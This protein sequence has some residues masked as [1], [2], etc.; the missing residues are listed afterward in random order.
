M[1]KILT[2]LLVIITLFSAFIFASCEDDSTSSLPLPS[3]TTVEELFKNVNMKEVYSIYVDYAEEMDEEVLSFEEWFTL[4]KGEEFEKGIIP[5]IQKN[6]SSDF[7]E[8]SYNNGKGWNSL[9][10]KTETE[11]QKNCK[12]AFK[13][14]ITLLDHNEF[15]NGIRYRECKHCNYKEY[16]FKLKHKFEI[17]EIP[18]TCIE[19]GYIKYTCNEKGCDYSYTEDLP[20]AEHTFEGGV[21]TVCG[22][23]S[24]EGSGEELGHTPYEYFTFINNEDG[25]YSIKAKDVNNMPLEVIL[26]STYNGIAVTRIAK[27]GFANCESLIK[28]EIPESYFVI[29]ESAFYCCSNLEEVIFNE[30]SIYSLIG[31]FAFEY[32]TSLTSIDIPEGITYICQETFYGCTALTTVKFP[33]TLEHID[34]LAFGNCYLLNSLEFPKALGSIGANAF[35]NCNSITSVRFPSSIYGIDEYAFSECE[36]LEEVIFEENASIMVLANSLFYNCV[37]L[38]TVKLPNSITHIQPGVFAGCAELTS[39]N[40]LNGLESIARGVFTGCETLEK[41]IIPKS[42]QTM[43]ECVFTNCPLLTI[44]CEAKSQPEGWHVDWNSDK[45]PVV[46]GFNQSASEDPYYYFNFTLLEDDTYAISA[47]YP[48]DM[49]EEIIIPS[50]YQEKAVTVIAEGGFYECRTVISVEIP[51]SIKEIGSMAFSKCTHLTT[52]SFDEESALTTIG[53]GAFSEC[54]KLTTI[55]IPQGVTVIADD[56][57]FNCNS[58]TV[59]EIQGELTAIGARAFK[60]CYQLSSMHIP[61]TVISIEDEAFVNC[62]SLEQFTFDENINLTTIEENVL[63]GCAKLT[64]LSIPQSVTQIKYGAF[65]SCTGLEKVE[66]SK[67]NQ[68]RVIGSGAF[69]ETGIKNINSEDLTQL[70]TIESHAFYGCSNLTSFTFSESVKYLGESAFSSCGSL[71]SVY[72]PQTL[73]TVESGAFSNCDALTAIEVD[74]NHPSYEA[75]DGNLYNRKQRILIQYVAGKPESTFVVPGFVNTISKFAF[76]GCDNLTSVVTLN[77]VYTINDYAFSNCSNLTEVIVSSSVRSMGN[78]VF[79]LCDIITIYCEVESMPSGWSMYWNYQ[80]APVVWGYGEDLYPTTPTD[81]KYFDFTLLTNDNYLISAKDVDNLPKRIMIPAYYNGKPVIGIKEFGFANSQILASVSF[82]RGSKI[83]VIHNSAF[84]DCNSLEKMDIPETVTTVGENAFAHCDYLESVTISYGVTDIKDCAFTGCVSLKSVTI[85]STVTEIGDYAFS[86]CYMLTSAVISSMVTRINYGAFYNCYN[87]NVYCTGEKIPSTWGSDWRDSTVTVYC[88]SATEPTQEGNFWHYVNWVPTVWSS[89]EDNIE[90]SSEYFTFNLLSDGT[91]LIFVN[92][93]NNIPEEVVIPS[94]YEGRPVSTLANEAFKGCKSIVKLTIPETIVKIGSY[95]FSGCSSLTSIVVPNSVTSIGEYAFERCSALTDIV[96]GGS[97]SYLNYSMFEF[98]YMIKNITVNENNENYRSL[99]GN[100]Y[101]RN[102]NVLI[103]YAVGKTQ[104]EFTIPFFV[105]EVADY[106][107]DEA[108]FLKKVTISESVQEI[109]YSAFSDCKSLTTVNLSKNLIV[110]GTQSFKNCVSLTNITIPSNVARI[111]EYAF[112]GCESLTDITIPESV[113]YIGSKAFYGCNLLENIEVNENNE[114]YKSIDGN[115]Y[116]KDGTSLI[117]YATGK[118]QIEFTIP[119]TVTIVKDNAFAENAYL[120]E[121]I[122]PT[123]VTSIGKF[124]FFNCHSLVKIVIPQSVEEIGGSIFNSC[125]ALTVYCEAESQLE[126]WE[127]GWNDS[128]PV[129]WGCNSNQVADDEY[130][131]T[132]VD[133]VRYAIKNGVATVARQPKLIEIAVILSSI[134]YNETEYP[135]VAIDAWAFFDCMGLKKVIIP[136]GITSIGS[137][138]FNNCKA[139]VKIVIPQSV[140]IIEIGA[141]SST[142]AITIC[143]QVESKPNGWV[144]GWEESNS[145]VWD[146]NK[147]ETSENGFNYV[148]IDDVRYSIA[149][150][151]AT[152]ARQPEYLKHVTIPSSIVYGGVSY[153]VVAID[154]YAFISNSYLCSISI[155]KTVKFIGENAFQ[156]CNSLQNIKV[157]F[158]N[159]SYKSID[160]NLYSKDGKTLIQYAIGKDDFLFTIPNGVTTIDNSAFAQ[161]DKLT[162]VIMPNTITTIGKNAFS[163]CDLLSNIRMSTSITQ[164]GSG[165]FIGCNSLTQ[166]IIPSSVKEI[167]QGA[168]IDCLAL[169]IY[170]EVEIKPEA[171]EDGWSK[172]NVSVLWYSENQP[173]AE[174]NYWHYINGVAVKW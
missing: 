158:N 126:G 91:Y 24:G 51:Q 116:S 53:S 73:T 128:Q 137:W 163:Y 46:W 40:L 3:D 106:A 134:T 161:A 167:Q 110:I 127:Y 174:G 140:S 22:E 48:N 144:D 122:I 139:L 57:F 12:H 77:S 2:L 101:S 43:Q 10:F 52:V 157:D 114:Y 90:T 105:T 95:A 44:Y 18:S 20:L 141:F 36:L 68:V 56:T 42:V 115:L 111:G 103:K 87:L 72:I 129:V 74:E 76:S 154:S 5:E 70:T 60:F 97:V 21:C 65:A 83:S 66:F 102:G 32:C 89:V 80:N 100:L 133:G 49:P 84:I 37:A 150:G 117:Q 94:A 19:Q 50:T 55:K 173:E 125:D 148:V 17:E 75:V 29:D 14:W 131:Y 30:N 26:P 156:W 170:C 109:K 92:D 34:N 113:Y 8:I 69:Q 168:I 108:R 54:E 119:N 71:T 159:E 123:T 59:I 171:W 13:K 11:E 155:P 99:E 151:V 121:V 28:I 58:L 132:V 27:N 152:V 104:T 1:K 164:I 142:Y 7:W 165:A 145:V 31:H 107:F 130:V 172:N 15:F 86:G 138:A 136:D 41:I 135:V 45:C 82:E 81:N 85:P 120:Q 6:L 160:G 93:C 64:S 96:I 166:I 33:A 112:Y 16:D 143:C 79:N 25:S 162:T 118:T 124:A 35:S 88:Y 63:W 39:I 153:E 9:R 169:T 62:T 47:K 4:V 98:S 149:Q 78:Y 61:Q 67:N 38:T 147:N 146:Y 23:G